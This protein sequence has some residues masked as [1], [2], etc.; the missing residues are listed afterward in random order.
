M[1][2]VILML[3]ALVAFIF[4]CRRS[5]YWGR[6]KLTESEL[7]AAFGGDPNVMKPLMLLSRFYDVPVGFLRPDDV[8]TKEGRLWRYD[9]WLFNSGQDE[10]NDF[11]WEH[12]LRGEH[13][14]WTI[15]DFVNWYVNVVSADKDAD[16]PPNPMANPAGRGGR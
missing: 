2:Y 9:T 1:P 11:V 13:P 4:V 5:A 12:G 10:L 6:R 15:S 16:V 8:F 14:D 3:I 7:L